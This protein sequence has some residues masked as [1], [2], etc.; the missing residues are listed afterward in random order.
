MQKELDR[1]H[2]A[3]EAEKKPWREGSMKAVCEVIEK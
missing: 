2:S 3:Y 1:L